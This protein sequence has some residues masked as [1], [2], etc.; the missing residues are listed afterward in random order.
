MEERKPQDKKS[1]NCLCSF[2]L[3]EKAVA[4][5]SSSEHFFCLFCGCFYFKMLL[6][7]KR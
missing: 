3:Y 4:I 5:K 6:R 1:L 7:I 2:D